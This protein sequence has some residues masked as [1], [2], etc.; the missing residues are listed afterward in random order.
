MLLAVFSL[1]YLPAHNVY[2]F[3]GVRLL[4]GLAAGMITPIAMAYAGEVAQE[5]KEGR[6][7][8]TFNMAFYLGL[9]AGPLL[10]GILWH[11]FGMTS[12]FYAMSGV[13]ALAFLLVLPF[14]PEVKKPKA[15]KTEEHVPFKT[16]IKHDAAKIIL[17]ITL[18]TGFRTA[19]AV[20][21]LSNNQ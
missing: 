13:S 12:V 21:Q 6:A 18:I 11:L 5:G 10:G 3:T 14:L 17:L 20:P 7:M 9:A 2:T 4:N 8:G 15:S 19:E 16:I 1:L